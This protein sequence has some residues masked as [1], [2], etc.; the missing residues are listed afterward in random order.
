MPIS[1]GHESDANKVDFR[2]EGGIAYDED[3]ATVRSWLR[4]HA[5]EGAVEYRLNW[6]G[7]GFVSTAVPLNILS[8]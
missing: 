8:A 3:C 1:D 4:S 2:Q 7:L 6:N 5:M